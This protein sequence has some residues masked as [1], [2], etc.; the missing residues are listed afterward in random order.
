M[1][2]IQLAMT[3]SLGWETSQRHDRCTAQT[4]PK[5]VGTISHLGDGIVNSAQIK[6]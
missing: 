4:H 1:M 6:L 2:T 3:D 5:Q